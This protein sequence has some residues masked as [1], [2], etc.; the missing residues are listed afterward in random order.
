[1][2]PLA[3]PS[4]H[5]EKT[6]TGINVKGCT[7]AIQAVVAVMI[8]TVDVVKMLEKYPVTPWMESRTLY[9]GLWLLHLS[10]RTF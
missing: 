4:R 10:P 1:M 6:L 3:E 9:Q 5:I 7:R 2:V 8:E